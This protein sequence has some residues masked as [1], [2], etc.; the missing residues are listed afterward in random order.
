MTMLN[1]ASPNTPPKLALTT[2][3]VK[4]LGHLIKDGKGNNFKKKICHII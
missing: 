2:T 1:R 3:E 4:L